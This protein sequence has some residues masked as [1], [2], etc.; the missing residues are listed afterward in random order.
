MALSL[1]V[2]IDDGQLTYLKKFLANNVIFSK[3][4]SSNGLVT[5][6]FDRLWATNL[7]KKILAN[8]VIFSKTISSNGLVTWGF[9]R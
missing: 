5:W 3:T 6:G 8:N 7:L 2:L 9:D 1:R 4:I